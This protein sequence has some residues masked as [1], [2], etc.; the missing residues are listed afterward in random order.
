MCNKG[1]NYIR[2]NRAKLVERYSHQ[3]ESIA[4]AFGDKNKEVIFVMEPD[5]TLY[6]F[7][8]SFR[9]RNFNWIFSIY[10]SGN[11]MLQEVVVDKSK[12]AVH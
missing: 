3:A 10:S 2:Q 5:V 6:L 1:A 12:K 4:K 9:K 7:N 8:L 11:F